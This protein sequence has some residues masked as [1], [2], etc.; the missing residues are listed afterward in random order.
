VD[1][2]ASL[3]PPQIQMLS[4]TLFEQVPILQALGDIGRREELLEL[5]N[6]VESVGLIAGRQWY[7]MTEA[8]CQNGNSG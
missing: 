3:Q 4:V 6:Q 5:L 2:P 8:G 7:T 1:G